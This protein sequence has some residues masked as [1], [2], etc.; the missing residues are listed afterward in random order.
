LSLAQKFYNALN[1]LKTLKAD[2]VYVDAQI[3][4][5]G[6]AYVHPATH[7]ADIIVD[8]TTN[9]AY[10]ATE[11]TKLAG[12]ATGANNY[13]HPATHS[14]DLIVDGTTNKAYSATEKTKLAGIETA[15][16][17]NNISD[18]NATDLTDAGDSSLHYHATDRARANH[19]GTQS[20]DT[21]VDGTTNHVFTAADDTKLAGIATG[22][23]NYV[24]PGTHSADII[25]D[26]TTNKVYLAT[27]KTK[28]AGIATGAE[29]S[30]IIA[31]GSVAVSY[32]GFTGTEYY[33]KFRNGTLIK[34]GT[35]T[36]A[37]L[38]LATGG[39]VIYRTADQS[40]V[41]NTS[42]PAFTTL[43]QVE[44]SAKNNTYFTWSMKNVTSLLGISWNLCAL[45]SVTAR[46]WEISYVAT[47]RWA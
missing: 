5:S 35:L 26:G 29:I 15:A 1:E 7:S 12:I 20:A 34:Y 10:S 2:I 24:H 45:Y 27:E 33:I 9:K 36:I 8:G 46:A 22:A 37:S 39:T 25:T 28:L 31:E 14:A 11:K 43:P 42:N 13:V 40:W 23:N 32:S 16:E 19:T 38:A 21:V 30:P 17:V 3:A 6:S 4:A 18:V 44:I 41:W 47:G